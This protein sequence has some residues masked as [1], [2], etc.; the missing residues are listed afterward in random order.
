ML[1]VARW[2]NQQG[3]ET[4]AS[5]GLVVKKT[6]DFIP[7]YFGV[8]IGPHDRA[9]FQLTKIPNH[10]LQKRAPFGILRKISQED[11]RSVQ[12]SICCGVKSIDGTNFSDLF[13]KTVSDGYLVYIFEINQ[14]VVGFLA[15][16]KT[17]AGKTVFIDMVAADERYHG[18]G[19][20]SALMRWAENWARHNMATCI[21]LYAIE[22][23]VPFYEKGH[24][25]K[26]GEA[27]QNFGDTSLYV[28]MRKT[29]LYSIKESDE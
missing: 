3:V 22:D 26:V 11:V 10:R 4:V 19:V 18:K 27:P 1:S 9:Y 13:Y 28:K 8:M 20:G 29:I 24:F 6:S 7:T 14:V 21:E 16:K 17:D 2:L 25:S 15:L 5:Y 23:R 12:Q